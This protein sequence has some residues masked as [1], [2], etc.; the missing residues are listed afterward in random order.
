MSVT[1]NELLLAS[2]G[3]G[4]TYRLTNKFLGLLFAGVEPERIL[5]TTFTRKAAGEILDRVLE[6]LVEALEKEKGLEDLRKALGLDAL[7]EEDCRELLVKLTRQLDKLHVRTIDSFFVQ[8]VQLFGLE[9]ELPPNWT[10]SEDRQD[11]GL[12]SQVVQ[13]VFDAVEDAELIELLRGLH[14]GSPSRSVHKVLIDRAKDLRAIAI[15]SAQGA[16]SRLHPGE[17]PDSD[18]FE[19]ALVQLPGAPLH[20]TSKGEPDKRWVSARESLWLATAAKDW[21]AVLSKGLGKGLVAGELTFHGKPYPEGLEEILTP[22]VERAKYEVLCELIQRNESVHRLL[23]LFEEHYTR[24]KHEK[25]LYRFEDLPMVLAP[26]AGDEQLFDT[27]EEDIWFRLDGQLD[28]LLLD[29]FQDTSPVQWRILRSLASEIVGG[30][31]D[32]RTYFCVGDVKQSIYGFRQAEPRL[33]AEMEQRLPGLEAEPMETSYRSSEVVLGAVNRV[34]G[35]LSGNLALRG[36]DDLVPY[37]TAAAQWSKTFNAHSAARDLPGRVRLIEAREPHEGEPSRQPVLERAVE[38]IE[39][40]YKESDYAEIGVLTRRNANIPLLISKL[41]ARDI[42]ASGEGGSPL[43]DSDAVLVYISLL[44]LADH[45]GDSAA[46]FHVCTSKLAAHLGVEPDSPAEAQRELG[47]RVRRELLELGLG[48]WTKR[49]SSAVQASDWPDWDKARFGQ[50]LDQAFSFESQL[51]L[52]ASDFIQH[53]R[54]K[55]VESP[56]SARVRVMT[57]HASKGLEFDAVVLPELDVRLVGQRDSY[58]VDRPDSAGLVQTV[59]LSPRKDLLCISDD[60]AELYHATTRKSVKDSLSAL[61][62]A[63]TRAKR[64]LELIVP[65][66]DREKDSKS[67]SPSYAQLLRTELAEGEPEPSDDGGHILWESAPADGRAWH[68]GLEQK[69]AETAER[70]GG[71]LGLA[72]TTAPRAATRRAASA[73]EGGATVRAQDLLFPGTGA[74]L[75]LLVHSTFEACTWI[76]EFEFD[77]KS[78]ERHSADQKL[79]ERARPL[80]ERALASEEV[81]SALSR[82]GCGAPEGS[83]L[84][85]RPEHQFSLFLEDEEDGRPHFWNGAIDRL[86]LARVG[87]EVV[88]AEVLDY[89]SDRVSGSELDQRVEHY[90]PQLESYA[91]VVMEQFG[92]E[93]SC[94]RLKLAFLSPGRVVEL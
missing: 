59:V 31:G 44:Q 72:P 58:L 38:C 20:L 90:R 60:L 8:L 81:R 25:G 49:L 24:A 79:I 66:V 18:A 93:R 26:N 65:W 67:V 10:I 45:P 51:S 30:G 85:V 15:E 84:E 2:A 76:E 78:L 5:A 6:R 4:K 1:Q 74:K 94:I 61:Y 32:E 23:E 70:E 77:P 53:L 69:K 35:G 14:Q 12:R 33:L 13:D 3:T 17:E 11:A 27:R 63:M 73:E 83:E 29:E 92:L 86:V 21:T 22:I 64:C 88:W 9:L 57:V 34:F 16:W 89:K 41:R 40:L 52:R 87:G 55:S 75:G 91:R 56:T 43:T 82:K 68:D 7:R 71:P 37:G 48:E 39:A 47:R 54:T 36:N 80:I 28:H 42:D 46:G 19:R 50:L 62:V